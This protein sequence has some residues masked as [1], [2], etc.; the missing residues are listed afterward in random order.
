VVRAEV[1]PIRDP[2]QPIIGD[3]GREIDPSDHLPTDTW[4]PEPERKS[5][6]PEVIIRFKH[7]P[8]P[9]SRGND[10]SRPAG[11]PRVGFRTTTE[12]DRPSKKY[13]PTHVHTREPVDRTPPRADRGHD[14]YG[15]YSHNRG[16][17]TP[18]S[19]ERPRSS[20]GSVSPSPSSRSPL[21]DYNTGPP[22]PSKVPISHGSPGY[23]VAASHV[24]TGNP[25]MDA[26][27]RELKTIDIGTVGCSP[28]RAV[29]KYAPPRPSV[30]MG[31]AS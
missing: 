12:T 18:T 15:S 31:Y 24:S 4:A 1:E 23:P 3:D 30:T 26:L 6:K 14:S 27:S 17:S 20:R 9:T 5:R 21:Y 8:R 28:S 25:G 22:I 11:P 7:S 2:D 19:A 10:T 13:T 16:Y 29:R